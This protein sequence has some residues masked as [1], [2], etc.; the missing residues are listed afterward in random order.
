MFQS[1][2][3]RS[4]YYFS[5]LD[6]GRQAVYR[7][8]LSGMEG[9]APE[10]KLPLVSMDDITLIINYILL[11]NPAIFYITSF[12][13]I[14]GASGNSCSVRP[15]YQYPQA[16]IRE[17]VHEVERYLCVFDAAKK[18]SEADKERYVHDY[19]LAHFCY[20][21]A[22]GEYAYSVLGPI[23]R[24]SA[25]C[26]GIAKFVKLALDYL[27]VKS[28]VASGHAIHPANN[29]TMEGHAWNIVRIEGKNYHLDVTFDMTLKGKRNR[30]DYYNLSDKEIKRDHVIEG[31]LPECGTEGGDYF[32]AN[33]LVAHNRKELEKQISEKLRS[34]QRS[35]TVKLA[36]VEDTEAITERLLSIATEQYEKA[37]VGD[38]T[39]KLSY[40]PTQL[41]FEIDFV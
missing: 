8:L 9:F 10:I 39:V 2:S 28:L 20:D 32:S 21:H 27:Q 29:A 7:A 4:Y 3:Y 41:V 30:Y 34:G 17:K 11:D 16:F 6:A 40:N 15:D 1:F 33:S 12:S 23:L 36:N 19:C 31:E 26:E 35:M 24:Q 22:F 37:C 38:V 14:S 5:R 25:V 18:R 13:R